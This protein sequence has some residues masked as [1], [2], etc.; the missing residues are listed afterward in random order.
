MFTAYWA[1]DKLFVVV[2]HG[3]V[4]FMRAVHVSSPLLAYFTEYKVR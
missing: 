1:G 4:F 3:L 2:S